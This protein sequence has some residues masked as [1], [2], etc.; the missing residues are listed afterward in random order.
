M[1]DWIN[2][3]ERLPEYHTTVLFYA[4]DLDGTRIGRLYGHS[5]KFISDGDKF[6]L[7]DVTHWQPMPKDPT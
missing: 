3:K 1:S 7:S 4:G 6:Y 2:T 5:Q